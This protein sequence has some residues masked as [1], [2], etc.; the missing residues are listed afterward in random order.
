MKLISTA[1][2]AEEMGCTPS[3]VRQ[4]ARAGKLTIYSRQSQPATTDLGIWF[5]NRSEVLK[6]AKQKEK[7]GR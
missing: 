3:W 6:L 1:T 7:V 2:A 5:F 4:L